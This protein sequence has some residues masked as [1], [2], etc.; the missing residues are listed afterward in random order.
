MTTSPQTTRTARSYARKATVSRDQ[1]QARQASRNR[2]QQMLAGARPFSAL[3]NGT[4]GEIA[5]APLACLPSSIPA[6]RTRQIPMDPAV[7][8]EDFGPEFSLIPENGVS[9]QS[10]GLISKLTQGGTPLAPFFLR[11]VCVLVRVDPVA[12]AQIG[13]MVTRPAAPNTAP[14]RTPRVIPIT[15]VPDDEDAEPAVFEYNHQAL[16]GIYD[17]LLSFQFQYLLQGRYLMIN[18][19]A[20]DVGLVDSHTCTKGFGSGAADPGLIINEANRH[21]GTIGVDQVFQAPNVTEV[22]DDGLPLEPALVRPQYATVVAP[23]VFGVCYPVRPH[24]LFPGQNYQFLFTRINENLYYDRLRERWSL[25]TGLTK[26]D[27]NFA[28]TR[29]AGAGPGIW[30]G[31]RGIRYSAI[32][33]G[34]LLRGAEVLPEECLQWLLMFGQPYNT[35]FQDPNVMRE[36]NMMAQ[37]CGLSGVPVPLGPRGSD[38]RWQ[39]T[40]AIRALFEERVDADGALAGFDIAT[41]KCSKEDRLAALAELWN[42]PA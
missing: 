16:Q 4:L 38:P 25:P 20:M 35:L 1:V 31:Y 5:N 24:V 9:Q 22:G 14:I 19:R 23:G 40:K 30:G 34:T 26:P 41:S 10:T 8:D 6:T 32:Q 33:Y 36:I 17:L 21:L 12:W 29:A 3:S 2:L 18:E 27:D 37:Q 28:D 15:G 7:F 42:V 11:A 39:K 13:A